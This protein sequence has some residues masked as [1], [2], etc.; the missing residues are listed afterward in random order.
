MTTESADQISKEGNAF[1]ASQNF[2]RA[3]EMYTR[4]IEIDSDNPIYFLNRAAAHLESGHYQL[5][6]KDAEHVLSVSSLSAA[7]RQKAQLRLEKAQFFARYEQFSGQHALAHAPIQDASL[8]RQCPVPTTHCEY[9]PIGN[10]LAVSALAGPTISLTESPT[11]KLRHSRFKTAKRGSVDL[12]WLVKQGDGTARVLFGGIGDARHFWVTLIDIWERM[13]NDELPEGAKFEFVLNDL[14]PTALARLRVVFQLLSQLGQYPTFDRSKPEFVTLITFITYV[15]IGVAM[16]ELFHERLFELLNDLLDKDLADA[17]L[18]YLH[19]NETTLF[20]IKQSMNY[21][22]KNMKRL[23]LKRVLDNYNIVNPLLAPGAVNMLPGYEEVMKKQLSEKIAGLRAHVMQM[24]D[25]KIRAHF[26]RSGM[27]KKARV[28]DMRQMML[29]SIEQMAMEDAFETVESVSKFAD[30]PADMLVLTRS[31]ALL[32]PLGIVDATEALPNGVLVKDMIGI[33]RNQN[34]ASTDRRT[35]QLI[36][37]YGIYVQKFFRLN[38]CLF[39]FGWWKE[40]K[41]VDLIFHP[42]EVISSLYASQTVTA[43]KAKDIYDYF[44]HFFW[45]VGK[46]L[47]QLGDRMKIEL[48]HGDVNKILR[49]VPGKFHRIF[50]SNIPDYCGLLTALISAGPSLVGNAPFPC[51][52]T[53]NIMLNTGIWPTY[54]DYVHSSTLLRGADEVAEI[55]GL[56]LLQGDV[57]GDEPQWSLVKDYK[58]P[59]KQRIFEY[60][61]RLYLAICLPAPRDPFQISFE[62]SPLTQEVFLDALSY[63]YHRGVPVHWLSE[64][65]ET[66]LSNKIIRTS[67]RVPDASPYLVPGEDGSSTK[68]QYPVYVDCFQEEL[69]ALYQLWS[70]RNAAIPLQNLRLSPSPVRYYAIPKALDQFDF[71]PTGSAVSPCVA[72]LIIHNED[73]GQMELG[74][75]YEALRVQRGKRRMH[76]FSALRVYKKTGV[77]FCATEDFLKGLCEEEEDMEQWAVMPLR[78][79]SWKMVSSTMT[80]A[81]MIEI[82]PAERRG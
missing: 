52:L 30:I 5:A 56:E 53:C 72:L 45:R 26:S 65:L 19:M 14:N 77:M 22:V 32:L 10:D 35:L 68:K 71:F 55:L 43:P 24:P 7:S 62:Y 33:L 41:S 39:D 16:P 58:L 67:A 3:V 57:L 13:R 15:Y 70:A 48:V 46:C 59:S 11:G 31:K 82:G 2:A 20:K 66:I 54:D 1:Y 40:M 27:D 73:E 80:L 75:F 50:L 47:A 29:Q 4:A 36:E 37:S 18:P 79:D 38:P 81:D 28:S 76:L 42:S 60:L 8:Y 64:V 69:K 61:F 9:F 63:L 25:E 12:D 34:L 21:W 74:G 6:I 51:Y 17:D 44:G 49:I 23:P 78:T